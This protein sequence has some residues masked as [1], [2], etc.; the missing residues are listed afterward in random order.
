MERGQRP[1]ECGGQRRPRLGPRATRHIG[2]PTAPVWGV[3]GD[4]SRAQEEL[5]VLAKRRKVG[6][7]LGTKALELLP[8]NLDS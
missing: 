2:C 5:G 4:L 8:R 3:G 7:G 6:E 1:L